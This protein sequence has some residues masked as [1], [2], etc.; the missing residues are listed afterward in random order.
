MNRN[1]RRIIAFLLVLLLLAGTVA[2]AMAAESNEVHIQTAQDLVALSRNCSLDGWS[3][4]KTVYLD[5]DI[6]LSG[7]EFE[8]I[9][10]FGG[11][12]DGQGHTITGFSLTGSGNERGFFRYVQEGAVIQDLTVEGTVAP[13]DLKDS[14]GG[15]VGV[16]SGK[17]L[18]CAFQGNIRA[19]TNAGG[20]AGYN[21]A[22]GQL[23]NFSYSG[24]LLGEHY[25]GG[26]V[27]RNEGS[28]IRCQ[29]AGD[30]NITE[31]TTTVAIHEVNLS[32]IRSTENA[33]ACTDIGGIA[34]ASSGILQSCTN[35]GDVGYEHVGHNVGGHCRPSDGLAGQL[36]QH[37]DGQRQKG[38]GRNLRPDGA[39]ADPAF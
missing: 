9:P 17:L 16:N 32:T 37:G 12:F 10:I 4:G 19:G 31:V 11:T 15:L 8:P 26:I 5:A 14:I 23:I 36:R 7:S 21:K 28:I 2:P 39:P 35:N 6:D 27:G 30:V 33:P 38:R 13:T 25:V 22:S 3:V 20:V 18:H 24:T 29:N 34:G 1:N